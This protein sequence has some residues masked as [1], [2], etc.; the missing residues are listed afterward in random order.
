[1]SKSHRVRDEKIIT[2]P[3]RSLTSLGDVALRP[4]SFNALF[5]ET[6][7]M[8]FMDDYFLSCFASSQIELLHIEDCHA[9]FSYFTSVHI[10]IVQLDNSL[11]WIAQKR[12]EK[13]SKQQVND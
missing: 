9:V 13:K 12:G 10:E 6:I 1:M 5:A 3:D 8:S 7:A 2:H 4:F 11:V